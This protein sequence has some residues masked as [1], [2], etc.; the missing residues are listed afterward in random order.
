MMNKAELIT[1]VAEKCETTKKVAGEYVEV[2]LESIVEGLVSEG[3]VSL[4]GF[5]NFEVKESAERNGVNPKTGE[6][7]VIAPKKSAKF[8]ASKILKEMVNK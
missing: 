7:L 1:K 5:G 6:K 8:K 4:I 2:V 3:K